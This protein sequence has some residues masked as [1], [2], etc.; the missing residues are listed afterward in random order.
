MEEEEASREAAS[1]EVPDSHPIIKKEGGSPSFL[2]FCLA[3]RPAESNAF[4]PC[5]LAGFLTGFFL[6]SEKTRLV[7]EKGLYHAD[8]LFSWKFWI[9]D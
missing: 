7:V 8:D 6:D 1:A 3:D 5:F 4:C 2:F 9:Y